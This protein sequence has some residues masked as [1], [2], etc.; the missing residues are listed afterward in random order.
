MLATEAVTLAAA[1]GATIPSGAVAL[2]TA[3]DVTAITV[4]LCDPSACFRESEEWEKVSDYC[5]NFT[6]KLSIPM[7]KFRAAWRGDAAE[8]FFTYFSRLSKVFP[9]VSELAKAEKEL[10]EAAGWAI[11]AAAGSIVL[12]NIPLIVAAVAA[13]VLAVETFGA[14]LLTQ[15][16]AALTWSGFVIAAIKYEAGLFRDI[17]AKLSAVTS[18]SRGLSSYVNSS[19]TNLGRNNLKIDFTPPPAINAD[20][21]ELAKYTSQFGPKQ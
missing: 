11:L 18:A 21:A 17:G 6:G 14:S 3:I 19:T 9:M 5:S 15:W 20:I 13:N 10:L 12:L 16:V 8:S 4:S 2:V 7:E 1:A